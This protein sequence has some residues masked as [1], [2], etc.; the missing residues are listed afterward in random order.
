MCEDAQ[1][2]GITVRQV[3]DLRKLDR[4][5]EDYWSD[6]TMIRIYGTSDREFRV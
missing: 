5:H 4:E 2:A 3:G 6:E 1:G